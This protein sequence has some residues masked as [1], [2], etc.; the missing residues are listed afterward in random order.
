LLQLVNLKDLG[1][2]HRD[3][4]PENIVLNKGKATIIDYGLAIEQ[5]SK[6]ILK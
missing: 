4:K 6:K 1:I 2:I 3:L 5:D